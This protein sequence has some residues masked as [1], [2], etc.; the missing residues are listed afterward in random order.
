VIKG[1]FPSKLVEKN[2]SAIKAAYDRTRVAA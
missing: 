1:Y 2:I